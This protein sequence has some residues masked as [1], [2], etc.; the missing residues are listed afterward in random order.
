GLY[1]FDKLKSKPPEAEPVLE[2]VVLHVADGS[3][4]S[5]G[6]AAIARAVAIAE[7][8]TLAKDLGNMPGNL[9]TPT[10]LA[11][12]AR[13]IG[14]RHGFKVEIL[15]QEDIQKL[16]MGAFLAV[17]RGSCQPAKLI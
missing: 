3:E 6:E 7:G 2:K 10:Y 14:K 4:P 11:D 8:V 16:G 1:R 15:E 12:Q 13:E 5:A 9:C 17:A